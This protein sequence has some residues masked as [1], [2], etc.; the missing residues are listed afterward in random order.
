MIITPTTPATS[1]ANGTQ[2]GIFVGFVFDFVVELVCGE[3]LNATESASAVKSR[4]GFATGGAFGFDSGGEG[5]GSLTATFAVVGVDSVEPA[6]AANADFILGDVAGFIDRRPGG[7]NSL[8]SPMPDPPSA[9]LLLSLT[10]GEGGGSSTAESFGAVESTS[11]VK[12]KIGFSAGGVSAFTGGGVAVIAFSQTGQFICLPDNAP[13]GISKQ[14]PQGQATR[15]DVDG[16][17]AVDGVGVG[18]WEGAGDVVG[19]IG[20]AA[21]MLVAFFGCGK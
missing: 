1:A 20:L 17:D 4:F 6:L 21:W 5:S 16:V 11:A 7:S 14:L 9:A 2:A 3:E 18:A 12:S 15:M 19:G 13:A 8:Q 10:G